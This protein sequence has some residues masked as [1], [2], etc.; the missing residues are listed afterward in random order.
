MKGTNTKNYIL[1]ILLVLS[2]VALVASFTYA[3]FLTD[4]PGEV[5]QTKIE[6]GTF[7]I[8]TSL[9]NLS[10]INATNMTLLEESEITEKSNKINFTVQSKSSTNNAGRF[11]IYLKDITI[12]T[13]MINSSFKYQILMDGNIIQNGDFSRLNTLGIISTSKTSTDAIKYYDNLV[14]ASAIDF[15]DFNESEIEIRVYLL[16]DNT[17]NQNDLMNGNFSCKVGVEAYNK[18]K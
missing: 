8:A 14:L 7:D 12:S 15:D 3:F 1:A 11:N 18:T 13:G 2:I 6:S 5:T 9:T 4:T 16:N 17:V 10:G